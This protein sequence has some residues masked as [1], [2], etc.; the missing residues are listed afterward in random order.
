MVLALKIN[1]RLRHT[2]TRSTLAAPHFNPIGAEQLC[3]YFPEER[4]KQ[5]Q[6]SYLQVCLPSFLAAEFP[7]V[8]I[9]KALT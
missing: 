7:S 4:P 8:I 1:C 3:K 9:L 6:T 2:V 5:L